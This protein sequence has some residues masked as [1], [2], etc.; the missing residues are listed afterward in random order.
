MRYYQQCHTRLIHSIVGTNK[1]CCI[2]GDTNY[3][4]NT[5]IHNTIVCK[6]CYKIQMM[7]YPNQILMLRDRLDSYPIIYYTLIAII[8]IIVAIAVILIYVY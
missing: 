6:D 1:C 7:M 3:I 8:I 4:Y 5:N 2:C